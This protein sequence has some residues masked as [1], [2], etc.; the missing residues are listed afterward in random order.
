MRNV[1]EKTYDSLDAATLERDET[2]FHSANG[3]LGVRA[4]FEEGYG[5]IRARSVRGA[6][7][8]GVYDIVPM[9]QAEPLF[10]LVD[11]K[12]T[13]VNLAEVQDIKFF[14]FGHPIAPSGRYSRKLDLGSGIS[15][16]SFS[17]ELPSGAMVEAVFERLCPFT[18]KGSFMIRVRIESD[19]TI[20]IDAET[21][22]HCKV[23]NLA[24]ASDPRLASVV[25]SFLVQ[26]EPFFT[27]DG[28]SVCRSTTKESGIRVVSA[29]LDR[30]VSAS[31]ARAVEDGKAV[32]RFSLESG[33]VI[34]ERYVAFSD[35]RT[36]SDP[37]RDA[38]LAV[39]DDS[40]KGF[41][42]AVADQKKYL[43]NFWER[44]GLSLEGDDEL[45]TALRFNLFELLQSVGKDG[46]S[47]LAA[48]GL[49]GE[50]YEGHYFWDTEMYVQP[51]FTYIMPELSRSLLEYRY[52]ILDK[53]RENASLLGHR[54]GALFPWRT[55]DGTECSGFFP[56]GTAQYHIDGAVAYAIIEYYRM[57]GDKEFM[58]DKGLEMLLEIS[59][60][61]MDLG[62][63]TKRG[64]EL[65]DV[66]GPDEYTC[67]VNNNFYT[68]ASA[69]FDLA[70]T[71]K[72]VREILPSISEKEEA[73]LREFERASASMFLPHDEEL[74]IDLQDDSFIYKK[75]LDLARIPAS[76][77]PMLL[78]Y[79]PLFLYRHQVLKQA[80]AV[81]AELL[82]PQ[83]S[84]RATMIRSYGYYEAI[85]THDSSLSKCVYALQA[86]ALGDI[87]KGY[88][89][90]SSSNEIDLED[91][92]GNTRDGIHTA[93]MGGGY[94]AF[95]KGIGG[96]RVGEKGVSF[97]PI[98]PEGWKS[99]SFSVMYKSNRIT[100]KVGKDGAV[101]S[102][103]RPLVVTVHGR[104]VPIGKEPIVVEI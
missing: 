75:K 53:A 77:H 32:N 14:S 84:D 51:I 93:N 62:V 19:R 43:A 30:I 2:L 80:D 90:F 89:Y 31:P 82:Y 79:H 39:L 23:T 64:F 65:H 4:V 97:S 61:W 78:H 98:L 59:R 11:R 96:F 88:S 37:E 21:T 95:V 18:R 91:T 66:T 72:L 8:N 70:E 55:I 104:D 5:E 3:Y 16:R 7:I 41:E 34:F 63:F 67:I 99:Y 24:D 44:T 76:D 74:G 85:T 100:L 48:K 52:S 35:S 36:S 10:G 94:L 54:K 22:H 103:E 81:L 60:L 45:E 69:K 68:N 9:P 101:L 12:Q 42:A 29:V 71:A 27:S 73:E 1:I 33:S 15:S 40:R 17:I 92:H 56:A 6:Y 86:F 20:A 50:G 13:I 46:L 26:D 83:F 25:H 87:E 38:I 58:L 49:S 102:A 57:T 28:V 47:H